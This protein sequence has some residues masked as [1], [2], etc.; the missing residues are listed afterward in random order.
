MSSR[1]FVV[2]SFVLLFA[3]TLGLSG[4]PSFAVTEQVL[5]TFTGTPD[6]LYP[7]SKLL[8]SGGKFY[9][10]TT[11][12]GTAS[13]VCGTVFELAPIAGGGWSY[14]IIYSFTGSPDGSVPVGN[15]V[16]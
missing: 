6:G 12:G 11:N 2:L 1:F 8:Y 5:H 14:R 16:R 7:L 3:A 9:G 4:T 10:T 13:C 15:L